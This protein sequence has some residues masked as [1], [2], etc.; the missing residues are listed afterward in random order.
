MS[1][2]QIY[3]SF[4]CLCVI[5]FLGSCNTRIYDY[6][7][8]QY[9]IKTKNKLSGLKTEILFYAPDVIRVIKATNDTLSNDTINFSVIKKPGKVAFSIKEK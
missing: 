4:F 1:K 8:T 5:L 3:N 7:K 6:E 2:N 9:G